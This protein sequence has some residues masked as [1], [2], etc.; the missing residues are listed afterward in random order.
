MCSRLFRH[1][2]AF[3]EFDWKGEWQAS[4]CLLRTIMIEKARTNSE[5]QHMSPSNCGSTTLRLGPQ[6][7]EPQRNDQQQ[8]TDTPVTYCRP[9]WLEVTLSIECLMHVR[10]LRK[11]SDCWHGMINAVWRVK[12]TKTQSKCIC[13]RSGSLFQNFGTFSL[14]CARV[15]HL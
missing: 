5:K 3:L 1:S 2:A 14:T 13:T 6:E 15:Q 11:I 7:V 4:D 10:P 12:S 9:L 8:E